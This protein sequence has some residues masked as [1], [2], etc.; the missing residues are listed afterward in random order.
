M[1]TILKERFQSFNGPRSVVIAELAVDTK[2]ELPAVQGIDGRELSQGSLA[3]IV[4]TGDIFGLSG[5]GIW[6]DQNTGEEYDP[7]PEPDPDPE[8]DPEPGTGE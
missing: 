8:P 4:S 7:E 2:S 3:W 6:V 1:I 5:S